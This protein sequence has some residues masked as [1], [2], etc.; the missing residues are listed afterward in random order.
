MK[1]Q[2]A[3]WEGLALGYISDVISMAHTFITD[4]LHLICPDVRVRDGLMSV[5]MEELM[6]KYKCAL[7]NVRFLLHVYAES[8]FPQEPRG[9]VCH[10]LFNALLIR[11]RLMNI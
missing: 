1:T 8:W 4:L 11:P 3:K 9:E 6:A 10:V 5:M 2:S 7:D